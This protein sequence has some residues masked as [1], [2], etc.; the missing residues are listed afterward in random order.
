MLMKKYVID[1]VNPKDFTAGSKARNDIESI[2]TKNGYDKFTI[3]VGEKKK[4]I[5][6][7]T[8]RIKKQ[9]R[10]ILDSIEE[11]SLI[12]MQ[13]PWGTMSY[14]MAKIVSEKMQSRGIRTAVI[15]H[16]LNSVRTGSKLTKQYYNYYVK[17]IKYLSQFDYIV[18]H[19]K[20]MGRYLINN[21][22]DSKKIVSLGIFDYLTETAA[23]KVLI[24]P[25]ET[26][27]I[28]IAG[29]LSKDKTEYIYKLPEL[30]IENYSVQLYGPFYSGEKST[31]IIYNGK[32]PADELPKYLT[33]GFGLVWDGTDV[34]T[35]AGHFGQYLKINNPHKLSL[36]M[37]CGIPVIV[38]KQAAIADFVTNNNVGFCVESLAEIDNIMKNLT[39]EKYTEL[40]G[41]VA[42]IQQRVRNGQ[43]ILEAMNKITQEVG[44]S[45]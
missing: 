4:K 2:L 29:N 44:E 35:C 31:K 1:T 40:Q 27:K 37:A 39:V 8:Y 13:Y 43:Y 20:S 21:G 9:L 6:S 23:Q 12:V 33:A 45:M 14:G 34:T 24:T 28:N 22:I 38:W 5:L 42:L 25:K 16:D 10:T 26:R 41:N 36:Y 15:I 18:C 7:E 11:N 32:F 19:N 17:E 30:G 3:V